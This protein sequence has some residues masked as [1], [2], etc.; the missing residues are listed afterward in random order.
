[1]EHDFI[2]EAQALAKQILP[3]LISGGTAAAGG[4]LLAA[5]A[6]AREGESKSERRKPK[7]ETE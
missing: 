5:Q 6:P 1:M 7:V 2:K 3:Y 4:A